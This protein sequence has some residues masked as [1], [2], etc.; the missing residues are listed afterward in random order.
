MNKIYIILILFIG[1]FAQKATAQAELNLS[2]N[3]QCGTYSYCVDIEL[4]ATNGTFS[5]GTSSLL[6]KYNSDA[7]TFNSYTAVE[8][9]SASACV[10]A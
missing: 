4:K 5:L 2:S 9:D 7:L 6:L 10:G 3:L 1:A 8:F